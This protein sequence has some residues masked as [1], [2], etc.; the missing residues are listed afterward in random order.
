MIKS[1]KVGTD[2]NEL[3][4]NVISRI[5][6]S[7]LG[8]LKATAS[9]EGITSLN[10]VEKPHSESPANAGTNAHLDL[11]LLELEEYFTGTRKYF[12]VPLR[13]SGTPFQQLVW[14]HLLEIP[15]GETRSYTQQ[16]ERLG[17]VAAIRATAS[18]NGRNCL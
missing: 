10:F 8:F 6:Q 17:N 11:L 12:T 5:I 1:F 2:R 3:D 9:P 4:Q 14:K 15:F 13:P 16:S 18:A 7:P